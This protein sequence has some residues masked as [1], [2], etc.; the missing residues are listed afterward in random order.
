MTKFNTGNPVGSA[1]PRDRHDNSQAFD[2]GMNSESPSFNDRLGRAR[3]SWQAFEN[4]VDQQ[5]SEFDADQADREQ[6][7]NAFLASSGYSGTG[8]NGAVEDYAAGIE[9]TEYN[10]VLR[11]VNGEMWRISGSTTLPYTTTGS[12][13]PEG[14]AFVSV[15]D[16]VLRQELM[17]DGLDAEHVN[18]TPTTTIKEAVDSTR[19][20]PPINLGIQTPQAA[21]I[22]DTTNETTLEPVTGIFS[23]RS[24]S[25]G[26]SCPVLSINGLGPAGTGNGNLYTDIATLL[27]YQNQG[28]EIIN[29]GLTPEGP[30]IE[31]DDLM[32]DNDAN[33]SYELLRRAGIKPTS[34][35]C[36]GGRLDPTNVAA[37]AERHTV[38][39]AY[40]VA[41]DA[42]D[43]S[44]CTYS[45]D[46][47][48]NG[49]TGVTRASLEN[50]IDETGTTTTDNNEILRVSK[51]VV[52]YCVA[53]NR[54]V[55]F[56][57]H[58]I[59]SGVFDEPYIE[60]LLDYCAAQGLSVES[61]AKL[62]QTISNVTS[63]EVRLEALEKDVQRSFGLVDENL[64]TS[65]NLT[66]WAAF[67][68]SGTAPTVT[69]TA[70]P[71]ADKTQFSFAGDNTGVAHRRHLYINN[72]GGLIGYGSTLC[73]G[74]DYS[75]DLVERNDNGSITVKARWR[76]A[77]NGGGNVQQPEHVA[78][79]TTVDRYTRRAYVVFSNQGVSD[80][81]SDHLELV[82]EFTPVNGRPVVYDIENPVLNRGV[83]PAPYQK[84]VVPSDPVP[85]ATGLA[86]DTGG[87]Y[88]WSTGN[89]LQPQYYLNIKKAMLVARDAAGQMRGFVIAD[90]FINGAD[91][92]FNT[93]G[94]VGEQE[95]VVNITNYAV[96]VVSNEASAAGV[97]LSDVTFFY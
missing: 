60:A 90:P 16:A 2:R 67:T 50:V 78:T 77:A 64:I 48:I 94:G 84:P 41:P 96:S 55:I 19:Y 6:R 59:S 9:L 38:L 68:D 34:F 91:I 22:F 17:T 82:I 43:L 27:K 3:K 1:D 83:I 65:K 36:Y 4:Q 14:G 69:H 45:N 72:V 11:D 85:V 7:F 97:V 62:W 53:N 66:G 35:V 58:T 5:Q 46:T 63:H 93:F 74:F 95:M 51:L 37:Y 10:Q 89:S 28:H 73:F 15:G 39:Y 23:A 40:N 8:A 81:F 13:L 31:L 33:Y 20:K 54:S 52:D 24:L 44:L 76:S 75:C 42:R 21:F 86:L 29:H 88:T 71:W 30:R 25:V 12:G 87:S 26:I 92:T 61:P 18:Y 56:Y 70:T 80:Q 32:I 49:P 57:N 79:Y 47:L